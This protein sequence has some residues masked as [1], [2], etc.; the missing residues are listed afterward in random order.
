MNFEEFVNRIKES[1]AGT[2]TAETE[3]SIYRASGAAGRRN[4]DSNR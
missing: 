1:I 3:Q 4:Y 2:G